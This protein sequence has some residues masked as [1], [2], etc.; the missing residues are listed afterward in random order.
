MK[1]VVACSDIKIYVEPCSVE[2]VENVC[3]Y[4]IEPEV[5]L[6][7]SLQHGNGSYPESLKFTPK[8]RILFAFR[9]VYCCTHI[10]AGCPY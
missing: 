5:S 1:H 6:S 9:S 7:Y 4:F 3:K 2:P 8:P 10:T